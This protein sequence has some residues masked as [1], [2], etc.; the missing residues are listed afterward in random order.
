[1]RATVKLGD[2]KDFFQ[3]G[4]DV[5]RLADAGVAIPN[6]KIITFKY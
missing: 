2:S 6:E 5:A 4:K 1:M 3:R